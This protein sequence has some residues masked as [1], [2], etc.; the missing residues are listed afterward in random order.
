MPVISPS[1]LSIPSSQPS[2]RR[3]TSPVSPGP[4]ENG[5]HGPPKVNT[6][7]K[8]KAEILREYRAKTGDFLPQSYNS[9]YESADIVDIQ[10]KR[11]FPN[12]YSYETLFSSSKVFRGNMYVFPPEITT[13]GRVRA[14]LYLLR[15]KC[16]GSN[17]AT[18]ELHS[19]SGA[20]GIPHLFADPSAH[21][22]S[23]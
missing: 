8:T 4:I 17:L 6:H 2:S 9:I 15:K 11:S 14:R 3:T 12:I 20:L 23:C 7:G 19:N 16:V 5:V 21:P 18:R 10:G 22:S 13:P 1:L